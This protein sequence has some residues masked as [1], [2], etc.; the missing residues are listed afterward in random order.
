MFRVAGVGGV[1]LGALVAMPVAA[2]EITS[3]NAPADE[4]KDSQIVVTGSRLKQDPN[5]SALPLQIIRI[6]DLSREGI[7]S[8]EQAVMYLSSN[9]SGADNLASNADVISTAA[10][11]RGANGASFANLRGQGAASTLV[12]LNGRRVAAHGLS[13]AAV[14]VNQ[15]PFA[16][17]D[18]IEVLKDG[19]SAIYGTDAVGG[20]INYIT[21]KNYTGVNATGFV[22]ITEAGDAPIYRLSGT[23]G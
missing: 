4:A 16:A 14:D 18:R 2:Q 6:E 20:V 9:G 22:D 8:A 13:G 15:I 19:A 23:V 11:N 3:Q 7:N 5:N 1:A 12:L 17:I 21:K 10:A